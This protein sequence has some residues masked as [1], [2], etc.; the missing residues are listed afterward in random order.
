MMMM[1]VMAVR[2]EAMGSFVMVTYVNYATG[3]GRKMR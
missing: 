2:E 1:S 3:R